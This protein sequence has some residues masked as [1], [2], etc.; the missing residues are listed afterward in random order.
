MVLA[1][2]LTVTIEALASERLEGVW[3]VQV[4]ILSTCSPSGIP[5]NE[6]PSMITFTRDGKV[7]ETAG[8][9]LVGPVPVLRGSPGLG[10]WQRRGGRHSTATFTFFR[11]NVPANTFAGTQ[12]ITEDIELS[13]DGNEFT[14]T[15]T[16]EIR[17]ASGNVILTGC[18]SLT[19]N[20]ID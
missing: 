15:G 11:I 8:T 7:I 18:N 10:T 2:L 20:R 1:G 6:V 5:V 4:T 12:T 9:P 14:A 17:D 13:R 3:D 16:S 19:G